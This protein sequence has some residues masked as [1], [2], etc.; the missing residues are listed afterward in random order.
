MISFTRALKSELLKLKTARANVVIVLVAAGLAAFAAAVFVIRAAHPG[1][2]A[3]RGVDLLPAPGSKDWASLLLSL[4]GSGEDFALVVGILL[5]TAEYR[6]GT[7]TSTLMTQP[8]RRIVAAAKLTSGLIAGAVVAA[9]AIVAVMV[10]GGIAAANAGSV[11]IFAGQAPHVLPGVFEATALYGIYGVGV[12]SLLRNQIAALVGSLAFVA[13]GESILDALYPSVGRWLPAGAASSV[14]HSGKILNGSSL[15]L[16]LLPRW[17]GA[18]V[19]VGYG[20]ALAIAGVVVS[21][22]ADVT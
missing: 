2:F 22:R 5:V 10:V 8:R 9:G 6:H 20:V 14:D 12:G 3:P 4:G 7:I 15:S 1:Q 16:H 11:S 21:H 19:L 13:I 17:E 18:L